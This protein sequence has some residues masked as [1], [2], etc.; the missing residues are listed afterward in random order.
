MP[1]GARADGAGFENCHA[2]LRREPAQ[3]GRRSQP[4]KAPADD[5]EIHFPGRAAR[6]GMEINPPRRLAP[7]RAASLAG[8]LWIVRARGFTGMAHHDGTSLRR[9]IPEAKRGESPFV[10][11]SAQAGRVFPARLFVRRAGFAN[12]NAS[13]EIREL[14][15]RAAAPDGP[16]TGL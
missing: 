4:G 8:W 3:P 2:L 7:A 14:N 6:R 16:V 9:A 10:A 12:V 15:I 11:R 1:A 13:I 5:R